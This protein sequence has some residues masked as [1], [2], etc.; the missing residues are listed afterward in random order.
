M[1]VEYIQEQ[2]EALGIEAFY[3]LDYFHLGDV[4]WV[5]C[6]FLTFEEVMEVLNDLPYLEG[7]TGSRIPMYEDL[8]IL[9]EAQLNKLREKWDD[10]K[11]E[12]VNEELS[13]R[14]FLFGGRYEALAEHIT[15]ERSLSRGASLKGGEE[16]TVDEWKERIAKTKEDNERADEVSSY[17]NKALCEEYRRQNGAPNPF[18]MGNGHWREEMPGADKVRLQLAEAQLRKE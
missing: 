1:T 16:E 18:L 4:R 8:R 6:P 11:K 7:K 15:G 3:S 5:R 13:E 9:P 12:V 17:A 10:E 2:Y 14:A